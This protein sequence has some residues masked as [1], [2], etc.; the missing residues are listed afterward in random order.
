[1]SEGV[2]FQGGWVISEEVPLLRADDGTWFVPYWIDEGP[3]R[4]D[5]ETEQ[6]AKRLMYEMFWRSGTFA[7]RWPC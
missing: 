2:P 1:M 4:P 6:R 3:W 5:P 7:V